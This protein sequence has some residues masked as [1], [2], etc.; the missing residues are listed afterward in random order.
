[1]RITVNSLPRDVPAGATLADLLAELAVRESGTAVAVGMDVVP[2]SRY[3]DRTLADGDA[4][5]IIT[6]AA[7]G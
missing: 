5:E 7:G 3:A 1:M 2:R 4:V 6:A